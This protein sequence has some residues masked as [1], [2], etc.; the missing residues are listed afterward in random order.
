VETTTGGELVSGG[1]CEAGFEA[2]M[3][4]TWEGEKKKKKEREE[5]VSHCCGSDTI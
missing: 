3:T 1:G 2:D 5:D 4:E